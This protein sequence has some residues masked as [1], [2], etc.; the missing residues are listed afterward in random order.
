MSSSN[1]EVAHNGDSEIPT[2]IVEE[3]EKQDDVFPLSVK[4]E[5]A[6]HALEAADSKQSDSIAIKIQNDG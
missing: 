1:E 3:D 5:K 6:S 2:V 4:S